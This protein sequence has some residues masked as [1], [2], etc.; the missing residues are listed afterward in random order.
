MYAVAEFEGGD[1]DQQVGKR[2]S[3]S[4]DLIFTIE[5]ACAKCYGYGDRIH[6]HGGQE[7]LNESLPV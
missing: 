4:P 1:T 5:L 3:H 7:F 2:N 6:G